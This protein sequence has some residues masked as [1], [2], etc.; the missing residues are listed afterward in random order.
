M[1]PI[2]LIWKVRLFGI[3]SNWPNL[4]ESDF[5]LMRFWSSTHLIKNKKKSN[6]NFWGR[7]APVGTGANSPNFPLD[8]GTRW[9]LAAEI[10]FWSE[11]PT[12]L[13]ENPVR[14][15]YAKSKIGPRLFSRACTPTVSDASLDGANWSASALSATRVSA[16]GFI[17]STFITT[18]SANRD[19]CLWQVGKR[20]I[21]PTAIGGMAFHEGG[22]LNFSNCKGS[23]MICWRELDSFVNIL[24]VLILVI[25]EG[26]NFQRL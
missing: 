16:L 22:E 3:K 24:I 25:D 15:A 20:S 13:Q 14:F 2:F 10:R 1:Q 18:R 26:G 17:K 5:H 8:L 23:F 9:I 21:Q 6:L 11:S 4:T 19:Y 7:I 12:Q